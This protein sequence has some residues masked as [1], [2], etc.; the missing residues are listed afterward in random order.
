MFKDINK[1]IHPNKS[2]STFKDIEMLDHSIHFID[3][4]NSIGP[5]RSPHLTNILDTLSCLT[6][7]YGQFTIY[8]SRHT[9]YLSRHYSRA[10]YQGLTNFFP[11]NIWFN[12]Q[13]LMYSV[14]YLNNSYQLENWR[15]K[16]LLSSITCKSQSI[17]LL[18]A[19]TIN[20]TLQSIL[21]LS[22]IQYI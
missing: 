18:R 1:L 8:Q 4:Q 15:F 22:K 14:P 6:T 5:S 13:R 11:Y 7:S 10:H 21:E 9:S 2:L 20:C 16:A 12:T 17:K 3:W 19:F